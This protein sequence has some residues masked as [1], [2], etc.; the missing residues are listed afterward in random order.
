MADSR[1]FIPKFH[2]AFKTREK[3]YFGNKLLHTD[4]ASCACSKKRVKLYA[5]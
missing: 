3:D 5:D 2:F 1:P 4:S